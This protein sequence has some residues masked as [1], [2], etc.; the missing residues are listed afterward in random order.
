MDWIR[1]NPTITLKTS[2]STEYLKRLPIKSKP[3]SILL[4]LQ[5]HF[6]V[7]IGDRALH[8]LNTDFIAGKMMLVRA[9]I[10]G[11]E[12]DLI[13]PQGNVLAHSNKRYDFA[14]MV[15]LQWSM[16]LKI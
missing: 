14:A 5:N 4:L 2:G 3:W 15:P 6:N 8:C 1:P 11:L 10:L 16:P 13:P 7:K 9:M 12:L